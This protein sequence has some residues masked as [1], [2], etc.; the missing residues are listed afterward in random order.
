MAERYIK[1]SP[2]VYVGNN[3]MI[4]IDPDG[5]AYRPTKDST[6]AYNGFEWEDDKEANRPYLKSIK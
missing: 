2:Y 1:E 6:G 5:M 4:L 3:S